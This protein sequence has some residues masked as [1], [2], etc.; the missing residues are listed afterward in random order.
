MSA[1]RIA[2]SY[3]STRHGCHSS[4]ADSLS[5]T[6]HAKR[7]QSQPSRGGRGCV[8]GP[9]PRQEAGG[10]V[11]ET[12]TR[13]FVSAQSAG[14]AAEAALRVPGV[15]ALEDS[16]ARDSSPLRPVRKTV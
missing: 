8:A 12:P 14:A 7:T 1:S 15:G 5:V 9:S 16:R 11:F 13:L 10:W 6:G 2:L 3:T 4:L